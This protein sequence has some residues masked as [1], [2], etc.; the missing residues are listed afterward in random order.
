M[1]KTLKI[2]KLTKVG[3]ITQIEQSI[4]SVA[5]SVNAQKALQSKLSGLEKAQATAAKIKK[6]PDG[7]IRYY[8]A[9]VPAKNPGKTK[10]ASF[11]TEYDPATGKVRQWMESYDSSGNVNR[12]HPKSINGETVK[13][14]HYPLTG[15]EL[16]EL[17]K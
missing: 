5:H 7:R 15:K 17:N 2:N 14:T 6:L 11:V 12:V 16:E 3:Q 9:E 8:G 13:S 1:G 10:G 4:P